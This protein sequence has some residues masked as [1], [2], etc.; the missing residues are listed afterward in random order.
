MQNCT[1]VLKLNENLI[2]SDDFGAY[3]V[4]FPKEYANLTK[5]MKENFEK[6][7]KQFPLVK[8]VQTKLPTPGDLVNKVGKLLSESVA[9]KLT[10]QLSLTD[11]CVLF[12]AFG[13]KKQTVS[14]I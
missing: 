12:L 7:S 10:S 5:G 4:V 3:C 8:L 6:I 1:E 14:F 2:K 11:D 9:K 13:N